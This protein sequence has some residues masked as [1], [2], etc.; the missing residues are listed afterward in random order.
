[1][2][3][4][5]GY[6]TKRS[7][8]PADFDN[9]QNA[10]SNGS[11]RGPDRRIDVKGRSYHMCFHR[12]AIH[13]LSIHGDQPFSFVGK[14]GTYMTYMCN[15]E[16]YNWKQLIEKYNF[17]VHSTSDCEVIGHL[18]QYYNYDI[19]KVVRALD[20]EF[21]IVCR[22][23]MPTGEVYVHAARDPF[24]V[25]PLYFSESSESVVF[26]STL[27]GVVEMGMSGDHVPPG[28]IITCNFTVDT[29]HCYRTKYFDIR[30]HL[31]NISN[32]VY[33]HVTSSLIGAVERRLDSERPIGFLLSGGLDSSL[34][35]AI[36]SKILG[37]RGKVRTFSIGMKGSVDLKYARQ[38]ADYL[39]TDHME[40]VFTEEEGLEAIPDV[41]RMLETYDITTIRASVGQYL[42]AKYIRDNTNVRVILNGDGADETECGYLYFYYAPTSEDAHLECIRLLENIHKYDGL[43]VDRTIASHGL[44]ARLPFLDTKFVETYLSIP[45]DMR[46]PTKSRMEKQLIREAFHTLYPDLLPDSVM[47][48]IKNAFSDAVSTQEKS[49]YQMIQDFVATKFQK[50]EADYYKEL[51]DSH[52]PNHDHVLPAY[53]MPQ[54]VN[55]TDPS[56]RTLSVFNETK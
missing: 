21:A 12:L 31:T 15:G 2:C 7:L 32:D 37:L 9:H 30:N 11:Q 29:L 55:A 38:V 39:G 49:W 13:D 28:S 14:D 34:V 1:M 46:V 56:A 25:R 3:G 22:V 10:S 44:E 26:S 24:G 54:W 47:F 43:R 41:I 36:A 53:W 50:K 42:L 6:F 45:C 20:G 48:R 51:F 40:V 4:V 52:F 35:V 19:E 5:W 16:I 18:M 8:E 33:K 27:G 17:Q 23:E